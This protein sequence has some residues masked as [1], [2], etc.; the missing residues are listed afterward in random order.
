[1]AIYG[2]LYG[3]IDSLFLS[4]L[5]VLFKYD[6]YFQHITRDR[7][8]HSGMLTSSLLKYLLLY[9]VTLLIMLTNTIIVYIINYCGWTTLAVAVDNIIIIFI[10]WPYYIIASIF[11]IFFISDMFS[12]AIMFYKLNDNARLTIRNHI[13]LLA[14]SV[15]KMIVIIFIT[16]LMDIIPILAIIYLPIINSMCIFDFMSNRYNLS[17]MAKI[18]IIESH[19]WYF[20]GYGIALSAISLLDTSLLL[21][22]TLHSLLLP[23]FILTSIRSHGPKVS[24]RIPIITPV[25][26]II[27]MVFYLFK[28]LYY[29][30]IHL[31]Y[32][33]IG[34]WDRV[35]N[36]RNKINIFGLY[37]WIFDTKQ[38]YK[39]IRQKY[40]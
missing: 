14:D 37:R 10:G 40:Y 18:K 17:L 34:I 39:P 11:N 27:G 26:Y 8:Y 4:R 22:S 5:V 24:W 23:L 25:I 12:A 6:K 30:S 35:R 36:I 32:V 16:L 1:M 31:K 19:F 33:V 15:I 38:L 3:I 20:Y 21:R 2:L 13:N 9:M 28:I 29:G 7:D